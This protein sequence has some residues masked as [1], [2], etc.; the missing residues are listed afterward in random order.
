MIPTESANPNLRA[1]RISAA[2]SALIS[3]SPARYAGTAYIITCIMPN[4]ATNSRHS[5]V[6]RSLRASASCLAAS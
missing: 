4:P 6:R 2:M 3:P 5:A 1:Q